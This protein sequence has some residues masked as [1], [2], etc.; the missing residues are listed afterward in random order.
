MQYELI[1]SS[2]PYTFTVESREVAALVMFMLSAGCGAEP[3][4][5]RGDDIPALA[6]GQAAQ[7]WYKDTFG[8]SPG[9][10]MAILEKDVATAFQS[11][12]FGS[13]DDRRFYENE[14]PAITNLDKRETFMKV[15]KF[16]LGKAKFSN[17]GETAYQIA[18]R[19]FY[20]YTGADIKKG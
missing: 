1:N 16:G 8:R 11:F 12:I 19:I 6:P 18:N 9:E 14:L 20:K 7:E 17:I 10:A 15:C 2:D 3:Q 5:V 13:F 4:S